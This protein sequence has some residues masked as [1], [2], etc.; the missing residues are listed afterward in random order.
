M[1]QTCRNNST[2]GKPWTGHDASRVWNQ[3]YNAVHCSTLQYNSMQC[4]TEQYNAIHSNVMQYSTIIILQYIPMQYMTTQH[5]NG[6]FKRIFEN[7][8]CQMLERLHD[9]KATNPEI[10]HSSCSRTSDVSMYQGAN[11]ASLVATVQYS[12]I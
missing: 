1:F 8:Y 5:R 11:Q 7:Y 3:A 12:I 10:W 9:D 4:N 2:P 6:M